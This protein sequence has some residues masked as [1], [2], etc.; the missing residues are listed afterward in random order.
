MAEDCLRKGDWILTFT[1][2]SFW[3]LDPKIEEIDIVDIC[4][5]L[6][7]QPR[8]A[9]HT[10]FAY[11]V[12]QHSCYVADDIYKTIGNKELAFRG[13]L[14]DASEA[15]T[16]DIIKPLKRL[17]LFKSFRDVED[18]LQDVIYE[19]FGLRENEL[20]HDSIHVYD[21]RVF[22]AEVEQVLNHPEKMSERKSLTYGTSSVIIEKMTEED[23]VTMFM[24]R[25]E[26]YKL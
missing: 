18:N 2:K 17:D 4:V 21:V 14:H 23:V 8:Y 15:Y 16:N 5:A 20:Y 19:S 26:K 9:G 25:F 24:E 1:G 7:R 10:K 3:P 11:S 22:N 13:L 12:G 6:C